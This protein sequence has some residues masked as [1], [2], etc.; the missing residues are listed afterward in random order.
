MR[1]LTLLKQ[2]QSIRSMKVTSSSLLSNTNFV[3]RF[4][5]ITFFAVVV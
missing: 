2:E 5:I 1:K 3:V 4:T